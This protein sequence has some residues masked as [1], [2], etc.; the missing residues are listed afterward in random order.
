MAFLDSRALDNPSVARVDQARK[1]CIGEQIR[2]Q[3]AVNS[4]D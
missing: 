2:R 3:I 1:L 4:S